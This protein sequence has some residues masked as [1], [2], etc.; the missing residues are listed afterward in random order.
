MHVEAGESILL[1]PHHRERFRFA[2]RRSTHHGWCEVVEP[3]LDPRV[4][5][6]L[7]SLALRVFA[8]SDR[9]RALSDLA[10]AL[11]TDARW[12]ALAQYR[13]LS[14]A[15]LYEFFR[16]AGLADPF[17]PSSRGGAELPA[18][19]TRALDLI[20]HRYAEIGGTA[21]LAERAGV[22]QQHLARLFRA[23]LG[24]SPSAC[25]W[26][27]RTDRAIELIRETGLPLAAVAEQCGFRTQF[28]LSRRVH[29]A[30]GSSPREIRAR[31]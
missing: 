17:I 24:M 20:H 22:T 27:V 9:I 3:E 31:R 26:Q 25:L 7:G 21:A 12:S 6:M 5:A 15:I 29:D 4:E 10:L 2:E 1:L 8:V 23:H 18:P 19:V 14:E 11:K 13:S 28:H 30:S 16:S